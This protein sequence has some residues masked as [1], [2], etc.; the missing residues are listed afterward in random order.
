MSNKEKRTQAAVRVV[1]AWNVMKEDYRHLILQSFVKTGWFPLAPDGSED[2]LVEIKDLPVSCDHLRAFLHC[3]AVF[4][5]RSAGQCSAVGRQSLQVTRPG[6]AGR[7]QAVSTPG[8]AS[9]TH[10]TS[11]AR[12]FATFA[13][14]PAW[15]EPSHAQACTAGSLN[16]WPGRAQHISSSSGPS[17]QAA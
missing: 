7:A 15:A 16:A 1:V 9:S 5:T 2:H 6:P 3:S 13:S 11:H 14:R 4:C 17:Q 10:L 12:H 8:R